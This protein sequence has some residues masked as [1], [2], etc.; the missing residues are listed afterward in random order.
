MQLKES[1]YTVVHAENEYITLDNGQQ[2]IDGVSSW[3]AAIHGYNH[4]ELNEAL[5]EQANKFAHI[6]LGG[7]THK[8]AEDFAEKLVQITPKGLNHIR[9]FNQRLFLPIHDAR[10]DR[11]RV[12][13]PRKAIVECGLRMETCTVNIAFVIVSE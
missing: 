4:P 11:S 12:W 9:C 7:L 5:S 8:P 3:W 10:N 1:R 6:M 13:G 2:L